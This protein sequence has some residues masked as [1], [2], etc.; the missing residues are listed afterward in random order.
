[1]KTNLELPISDYKSYIFQLAKMNN[2]CYQPTGYSELAK[3]IT[4]LSDD[5]G[6]PDDIESLAIALKKEK[7]ITGRQMVKLL[8]GYF[9]EEFSNV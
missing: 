4:L 1:M 9:N 2:I 5:N 3:T 7:I 6:Q 8:N